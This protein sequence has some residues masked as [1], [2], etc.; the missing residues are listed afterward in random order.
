MHELFQKPFDYGSD[1]FNSDS[2]YFYFETFHLHV[3]IL[4]LRG[5]WKNGHAFWRMWIEVF[6]ANW[7]K[8]DRL[9]VESV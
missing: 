9:S 1:P 2:F 8:N 6:Y 5:S 4:I 3:L 7:S